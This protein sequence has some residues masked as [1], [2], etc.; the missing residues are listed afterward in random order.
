MSWSIGYLPAPDPDLLDD[1]LLIVGRALYIA[2]GLEI[3]CDALL[4]WMK[5]AEALEGAADPLAALLA[6]EAAKRDKLLGQSIPGVTSRWGHTPQHKDVLDKARES[7]NFV[8]HRAAGLGTIHSI[9]AE[10]LHDSI[11]SLV[12]HVS[13]LA[14]GDNL[15]STWLYEFEETEP[16]PAVIR[17]V[18]EQLVLEWV[19]GDYL[20]DATDGDGSTMPHEQP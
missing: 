13:E 9:S 7:R 6:H 17:A 14:K 20:A 18:Y 15:V 5:A 2:T 19:F 12:P 10:T 3:K 16:A 8:A 1:Y 11:R 4:R